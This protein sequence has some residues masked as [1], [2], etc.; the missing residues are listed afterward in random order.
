MKRLTDLIASLRSINACELRHKKA[1]RHV[2]HAAH[3]GYFGWYV[4]DWHAPLS[5]FCVVLLAAALAS[6][7]APHLELE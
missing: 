3:S 2:H 6:W 1:M 7:I 5:I 4:F